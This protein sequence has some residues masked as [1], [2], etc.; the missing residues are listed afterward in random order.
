MFGRF[1]RRRRTKPSNL[2]P[3]FDAKAWRIAAGH[4]GIGHMAGILLNGEGGP[5]VVVRKADD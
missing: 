3:V 2:A 4:N 5:D 1:L